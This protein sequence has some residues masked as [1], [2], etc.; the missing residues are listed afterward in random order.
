MTGVIDIDLQQCI[1]NE[2]IVSLSTSCIDDTEYND[3]GDHTSVL[4]K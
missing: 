1:N 4:V 2:M 3:N